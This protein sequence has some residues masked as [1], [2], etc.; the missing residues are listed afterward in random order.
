MKR[1]WNL[2]GEIFNHIEDENLEDF[3]DH[4][5]DK[6]DPLLG[7]ERLLKHVELLVDAGFVLGVEVIRANGKITGYGTDEPRITLE[8][9]DFADIVQDKKLLSRT[10]KTIE[11]AGFLVTM[12]TLK[13]YAPKV[14]QLAV[15]SLL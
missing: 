11:K 6:T 8:G 1:D 14:L 3:I 15:T 4:F 2:L 5:E 12:E 13:A 10:I 9:Y 7:N